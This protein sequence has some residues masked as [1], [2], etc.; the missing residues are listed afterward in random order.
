MVSA[1]VFV[2]VCDLQMKKSEDGRRKSEV[3]TIFKLRTSVF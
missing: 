3:K 1:D 2:I